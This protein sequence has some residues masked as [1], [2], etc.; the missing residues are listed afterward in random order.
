[1]CNPCVSLQFVSIQTT[2]PYIGFDNIYYN[3]KL[4]GRSEQQFSAQAQCRVMALVTILFLR[5]V[6]SLQIKI[7]LTLILYLLCATKVSKA[8]SHNLA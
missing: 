5:I 8:I 7:P 6:A 3:T 4:I 1:M 2:V